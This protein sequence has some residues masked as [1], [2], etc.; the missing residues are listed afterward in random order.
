[1]SGN[2]RLVIFRG[3]PGRKYYPRRLEK[4]RQRYGFNLYASVLMSNQGA[5]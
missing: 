1:M 5:A 4:Y 3:D 2:Q